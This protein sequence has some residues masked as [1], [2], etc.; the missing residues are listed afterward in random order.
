MKVWV[1]NRVSIKNES[2]I[3]IFLTAL[4][5]ILRGDADP[6]SETRF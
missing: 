4:G 3:K 5:E 2:R 1:S 6:G